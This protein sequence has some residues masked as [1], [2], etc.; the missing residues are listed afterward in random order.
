LLLVLGSALNAKV[1]VVL[2]FHTLQAEVASFIPPVLALTLVA[3]AVAVSAVSLY[4]VLKRSAVLV[5]V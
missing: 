5:R 1:S 3:V 2:P 4:V